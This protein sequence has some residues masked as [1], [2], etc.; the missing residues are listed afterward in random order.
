MLR[1][2][3][4]RIVTNDE[5]FKTSHIKKHEMTRVRDSK[6]S[7][8][9]LE[10]N[11]RKDMTFSCNKYETK[12]RTLQ[13]QIRRQIEMFMSLT[14]YHLGPNRCSLVDFQKYS[15][16]SIDHLIE[17]SIDSASSVKQTKNP[18]P[19]PN[20][21]KEESECSLQFD[22]KLIYDFL[23]N[24]IQW[25]RLIE[26]TQLERNTKIIGNSPNN[27][28]NFS[29]QDETFGMGKNFDSALDI[30]LEKINE[31]HE[32]QKTLSETI[33][34]SFFTVSSHFLDM[35]EEKM[36][37]PL[38]DFI[39]KTRNILVNIVTLSNQSNLARAVCSLI[40]DKFD[41]GFVGAEHE[42][43][44]I[45]NSMTVRQHDNKLIAL[46]HNAL[47]L[48][49][50]LFKNDEIR[51]KAN[52]QSS[53][54]IKFSPSTKEFAT[55]LGVGLVEL[56]AAALTIS[57]K[58]SASIGLSMPMKIEMMKRIMELLR[59]LTMRCHIESKFGTCFQHVLLKSRENPNCVLLRIAASIACLHIRGYHLQLQCNTI[60]VFLKQL[61][62]DYQFFKGMD[63]M[64]S[65]QESLIRMYVEIVVECPIFNNVKDCW[66]ATKPLIEFCRN[67]KDKCIWRGIGCILVH[68]AES[69]LSLNREE[70]QW[71]ISILNLNFGDDTFASFWG[72]EN[73]KKEAKDL[74][75]ILIRM[76]ILSNQG[77]KSKKHKIV[78]TANRVL[79]GKGDIWPFPYHLSMRIICNKYNLLESSFIEGLLRERPLQKVEQSYIGRGSNISTRERYKRRKDD[80][81]QQELMKILLPKQI[82]QH[83]Q[84]FHKS[85][86]A[87]PHS[88]KNRQKL[89]LD[90]SNNNDRNN[91]DQLLLTNS[92]EQ[93][94]IIANVFSFL[95]YKRLFKVMQVCR[96]W[97]AV[98][99]NQQEIW[100]NIYKQRFPESI[101]SNEMTET[102]INEN[103]KWYNLFR[104]KI[105]VERQIRK[106][107]MEKEIIQNWIP[108][109]CKYVGCNK[110]LLTEDMAE[111]HD[112]FHS[113]QELQ[114][115]INNKDYSLSKK[116]CVKRSCTD[117]HSLISCDE[118]GTKKQKLS[119]KEDLS[120]MLT[121][122]SLIEV[123]DLDKT[124]NNGER[125][126][127]QNHPRKSEP[128]TLPNQSNSQINF[129]ATELLATKIIDP[130]TIPKCVTCVN[131]TE[132]SKQSQ[133]ND[134]D[135]EDL[136][137]HYRKRTE[138]ELSM[139]M[140]NMPPTCSLKKSLSQNCSTFI[141]YDSNLTEHKMDLFHKIADSSTKLFSDYWVPQ[142]RHRPN[143][144]MNHI[145]ERKIDKLSEQFDTSSAI[146]CD[147]G[148]S[149]WSLPRK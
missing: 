4:T 109:C 27:H 60:H 53:M 59:N 82:R 129:A 86:D 20:S 113:R 18:T 122:K 2:L 144:K 30:F 119:M 146:T 97:N 116:I 136:N 65:R 111:N 103:K 75:N 76:G 54:N 9:P 68:R 96:L 78:K 92:G 44:N 69:V 70:Y 102:M 148:D 121:S 131:L 128:E 114:N 130:R 63:E 22:T 41:K 140:H 1:E 14:Q 115:I 46:I 29:Q 101:F 134:N 85:R 98:G 42:V 142:Y 61:M 91:Q 77:S 79:E 28:C 73:E 125:K 147:T 132:I 81:I 51:R 127:Q 135:N 94:I 95:N 33:F 11:V 66:R 74:K 47:W 55:S 23:V 83:Y 13:F 104:Q 106:K 99:K 49:M 25:E 3:K 100:K 126:Y 40:K 21:L 137:H 56:L 48:T 50:H 34:L 143:E 24:H 118:T 32:R 124:L 37:E 139:D 17:L 8:I 6:A 5:E 93:G 26:D 90:D 71:M 149:D 31:L 36:E 10:H 87:S 108:C 58:K 16:K 120:G 64:K 110:I 112:R 52:I 43:H 72:Y 15:K 19:A 67:K 89:L 35:K 145:E 12:N 80:L 141:P 7:H 84:R 138:S 117:G 133:Q 105:S 88:P 39:Q 123:H 45:L 107:I 57:P 38:Q 62:N